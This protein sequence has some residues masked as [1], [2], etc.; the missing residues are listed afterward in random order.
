MRYKRLKDEIRQAYAD[1]G[2]CM[3]AITRA[4]GL[5]YPV[6][7]RVLTEPEHTHTN[8]LMQILGCMGYRLTIERIMDNGDTDRNR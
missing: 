1:S 4:T 8:S 3:L 7:L 6:I 2:L 5:S